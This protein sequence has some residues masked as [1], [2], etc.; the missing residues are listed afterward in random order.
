MIERTP[1]AH[2][3]DEP[4]QDDAREASPPEAGAADLPDL[5]RLKRYFTEHEQLT[6]EA[7]RNS[8]TAIDYYDTDQFTREELA[9]LRERGQPAIIINRIKPAIN[10]IIGVMWVAHDMAGLGSTRSVR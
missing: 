6:Y 4:P 7:R 1:H 9:R 8:L 3:P 10:G 2:R 5:M